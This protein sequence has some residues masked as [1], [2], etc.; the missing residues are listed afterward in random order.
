MKKFMNFYPSFIN[1][2]FKK[3]E[4]CVN[5]HVI[6][7][8]EWGTFSGRFG[9]NKPPVPRK[10]GQIPPTIGSTDDNTNQVS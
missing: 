2:L 7:I 4:K 8:S 9:F 5:E 6:I 1:K 3:Y 10:Q